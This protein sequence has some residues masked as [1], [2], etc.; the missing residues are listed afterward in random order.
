MQQNG[1]TI[2]QTD[3]LTGGLVNKQTGQADGQA[4]GQTG[5]QKVQTNE[6]TS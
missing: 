1:H 5:R 4:D 2:M 6:K 3:D